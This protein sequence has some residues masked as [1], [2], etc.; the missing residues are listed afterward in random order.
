MTKKI[1]VSV[2]I[3]EEFPKSVILRNE[4]VGQFRTKYAAEL[5]VPVNNIELSTETKKLTN[6]SVRLADQVEEDDTIHV[7]P[8]AKAGR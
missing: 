4:T 2:G 1:F 7:I 6:D 8:R 3:D 5:E